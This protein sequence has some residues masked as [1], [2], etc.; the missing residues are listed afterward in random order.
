MI[1][2]LSYIFGSKTKVQE[3]VLLLHNAKEV[4]RQGFYQHELEKIEKFCEENGIHLVKSEFKV[5]I[6]DEETGNYSNKGIRIDKK[7]KREGMYFVYLSKSEQKAL[8]AAY[9]ELINNDKDLGR[10]LGYPQCCVEFF[11]N[12]FSEDNTNPK[13]TP[14]NL[15]TNISKREEDNVLISHFPC[16]SDCIRSVKIGKKNL[17]IIA[18]VDG[19]RARELF[20][21]LN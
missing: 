20:N 9:Y 12:N 18:S 11:C 16:S 19:S 17:E 15:F 10:L 8:L 7:D 4:V 6:S 3:I 14:T 21:S 1:K 2:K 5:L 13:L